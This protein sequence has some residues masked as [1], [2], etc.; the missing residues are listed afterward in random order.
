MS[1]YIRGPRR[2]DSRGGSPGRRRIDRDFQSLPSRKL[3]VLTVVLV[4]AFYL[5]GDAILFGQDICPN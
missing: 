1:N 5:A 3:L 2:D 4:D